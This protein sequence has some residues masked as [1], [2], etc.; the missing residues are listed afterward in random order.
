MDDWR[1]VEVYRKRKTINSRITVSNYT[2]VTRGCLHYK[3]GVSLTLNS[4]VENVFAD[5]VKDDRT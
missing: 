4:K 5:G 3:W 2:E 1:N